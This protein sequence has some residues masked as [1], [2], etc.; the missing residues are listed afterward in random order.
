MAQLRGSDR[1]LPPLWPSASSWGSQDHVDQ[2]PREGSS[3][4][5]VDSSLHNNR[6]PG[7]LLAQGLGA[8][9]LNTPSGRFLAQRNLRTRSSVSHLLGSE[10]SSQGAHALGSSTHSWR[11]TRAASG[12]RQGPWLGVCGHP[13]NNTLS[14]IESAPSKS[15]YDCLII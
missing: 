12:E 14:R 8:C 15:E 4:H 10:S 2:S 3:G 13:D 5:R 7:L 6:K 11:R 9:R 1:E